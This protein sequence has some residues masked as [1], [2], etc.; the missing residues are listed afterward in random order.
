[1]KAEARIS[2][3]LSGTNTRVMEEEFLAYAQQSENSGEFDA[4]IGLA[5]SAES[6]AAPAES[7]SPERLPG[8][9]E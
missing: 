5:E 7:E 6:S 4:L 3:E 8:L 2:K 9:P 1:V